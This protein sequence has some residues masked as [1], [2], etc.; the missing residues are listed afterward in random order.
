[1]N[2]ILQNYLLSYFKKFRSISTITKRIGGLSMKNRSA[3]V[4]SVLMLL[5]LS[6]CGGGSASSEPVDGQV[7]ESS[8]QTLSVDNSSDIASTESSFE[9]SAIEDFPETT[10]T[11]DD[12]SETAVVNSTPIH[13]G[14]VGI[15]DGLKVSFIDC[16][17][18]EQVKEGTYL[19]YKPEEGFIYMISVLDI[20]SA[21]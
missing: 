1:M 21:Q 8:S 19:S 9:I 14:E 16:F 20:V 13:V 3:L 15:I 6:A 18:M 12:S 4:L 10:T 7:S 2:G 11:G 17:P 5:S